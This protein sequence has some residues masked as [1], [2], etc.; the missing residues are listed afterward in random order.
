MTTKAIDQAMKIPKAVAARIDYEGDRQWD[1]DEAIQALGIHELASHL[2]QMYRDM[3]S[4]EIKLR[5]IKDRIVY[6]QE[7]ILPSCL[8]AIGVDSI[9]FS[10][11]EISSSIPITPSRALQ[12]KM[13]IREDVHAQIIEKYHHEA[14]EWLREHGHV[15]KVLQITMMKIN[16]QTLKAIMRRAAKESGESIKELK[17]LFGFYE[18]RQGL[19]KFMNL[20]N[21]KEK[22]GDENA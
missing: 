17:R 16:A 22:G 18:T 8:D 5:Y 19:I 13:Y 2:I 4:L 3:E 1:I 10:S 9:S 15:D 21:E 14:I 11:K 7:T 20:P 12:V 6:L